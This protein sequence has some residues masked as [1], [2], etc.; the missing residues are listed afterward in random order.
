MGYAASTGGD[1][2]SMNSTFDAV[3]S[4][5]TD[6]GVNTWRVDLIAFRMAKRTHGNSCLKVAIRGRSSLCYHG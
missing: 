1:V 4:R 6:R 3:Y 2:G 5:V